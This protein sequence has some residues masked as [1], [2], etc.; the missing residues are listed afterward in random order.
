MKDSRSSPKLSEMRLNP[1]QALALGR[2][3]ECED[4][5]MRLNEEG[6]GAIAVAFGYRARSRR[7]VIAPDGTVDRPADRPA[8]RR[9]GRGRRRRAQT[10]R[11]TTSS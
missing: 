7:Y 11:S 5:P 9:R 1:S 10:R 3:V 6:D 2:L 4:A 8:N